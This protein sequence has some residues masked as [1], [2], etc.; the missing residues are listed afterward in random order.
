M[1]LRQS[2]PRGK[3][4]MS[5]L[6][7]V[8]T[9]EPSW[10][11]PPPT[12]HSGCWRP[13]LHRSL[14]PIPPS[15]P[16]LLPLAVGGELLGRNEEAESEDRFEFSWQPLRLK[17]FKLRLWLPEHWHIQTEAEHLSEPEPQLPCSDRPGRDVKLND[18]P[19]LIQCVVE[20]K[21]QQVSWHM[22]MSAPGSGGIGCTSPALL[23][24]RE[25]VAVQSHPAASETPDPE[26][27]CELPPRRGSGGGMS[28]ASPCSTPG[29]H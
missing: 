26:E 6:Y 22:P 3:G 10:T 25:A 17:V 13:P 7:P 15:G 18:S 12:S 11:S 5:M 29:S 14:P 19:E 24:K 2:L 1:L 23:L 4:N 28:A 21:C 16:Y 27:A 20:R 8:I 9:T